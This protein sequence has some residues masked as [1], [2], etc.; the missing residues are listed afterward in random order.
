ML[1]L[2]LALAH[3]QVNTENLAA[4]AEAE[5]FGLTLAAGSNFTYG[6]IDYLDVRGDGQLQLRDNFDDPPNDQSWFRDR[7]L[8]SFHGAFRTNQGDTLLDERLVHFRYTHMFVPRVG[9]EG[10]GQAQNDAILLLKW[11]VLAGGGARVVAVNEKWLGLW[12]GSGYM[13]EYED[14]NVPVGG[15]DEPVV[16]NHRWTNYVSVRASLIED[17]LNL[18]NTAYVQPRWDDFG[19]VQFL[20]E[21]SLEAMVSEALSITSAL[22]L[23]NDSRPPADLEPLDARW[24]AGFTLR[25]EK[26]APSDE[27]PTE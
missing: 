4:L 19:D 16:L 13:A 6:N 15:P 14:R 1:P 12:A 5:G 2:L 11:R 18:L 22:R 21:A 20:D 23:R 7:A 3:A 17:R 27:P 24:T 10:F 26:K 8:L 9:V 25:L